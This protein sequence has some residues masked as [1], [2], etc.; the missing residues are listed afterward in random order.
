MAEKESNKLRTPLFRAAFASVFAKRTY[1]DGE[2]KYELTLLFPKSGKDKANLK[3]LKAA[4][5]AAAIEKWGSKDKI[6]KGFKSPF[7]DGDDTEWDGFEGHTFVRVSS[8]YRPKIIN[9]EGVELMTD[10]EFYAG[11]WAYATVNAYAY[12]TKGNKGVS[13]GLQNLIFIRDDEPFSG[14]S[15]AEE[16]FSDLMEEGDGGNDGGSTDDDDDGGMFD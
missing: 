12:D 8:L 5:T 7:R 14:S 6:P 16:D 1:E 9:R 11:C 3:V 2:A 13:F 10:E 15:S 4:A